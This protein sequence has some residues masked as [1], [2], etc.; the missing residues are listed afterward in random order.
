MAMMKRGRPW[1][2]LVGVLLTLFLAALGA[3][4]SA[5][6]IGTTF[7]GF[8]VMANRVVASVSLPHW[9]VADQT[10]LYQAQV[11][12]VNAHP[13]QTSDELYAAVRRLP[14]GSPV[15]YRL[16]KDG[17][18]FQKTLPS[19]L[20]TR[21]DYGLLFGAYLFVGLAFGLTGI[22]VWF[23]TPATPASQ[24]FL[25]TGCTLGWLA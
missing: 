25:A 19:G 3:G 11:V 12:A 22:G 23:F 16:E 10:D 8:F 5:G 18:T 13:V 14:V 9:S 1:A 2:A 17:Q 6:W 15:T 20:F 4:L 24:A 7:P 21:K